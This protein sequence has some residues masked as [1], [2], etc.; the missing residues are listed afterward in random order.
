MAQATHLNG[1][2]TGLLMTLGFI[3]LSRTVTDAP[4]LIRLFSSVLIIGFAGLYAL[5]WLGA[6]EPKGDARLRKYMQELKNVNG[7]IQSVGGRHWSGAT[8]KTWQKTKGSMGRIAGR[9]PRT[10][11][12]VLRWL[13]ALP[14]ALIAGDMASWLGKTVNIYLVDYFTGVDPMSVLS[15]LRTG[16]VSGL[17][18]GLTAIYVVYRLAPSHKRAAAVAM[19]ALGVF[20]LGFFFAAELMLPQ[21][22]SMWNLYPVLFGVVGMGIATIFA[23]TGWLDQNRS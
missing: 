8:A 12:T 1:R 18:Y 16:A 20:A 13:L 22:N 2:D 5:Q 17:A 15:R 19:S 11:T 14:A 9:V 6:F 4:D 21:Y 7:K 10:A 23:F 3:A